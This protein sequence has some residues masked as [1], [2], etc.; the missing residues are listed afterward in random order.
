MID[1]T[2]NLYCVEPGI[3]RD[4]AHSEY[5]LH[6]GLLEIP[7]MDAEDA[8]PVVVRVHGRYTSRVSQFQYERES[9]PP[10]IPAPGDLMNYT[11]L[12]GEITIPAPAGQGAQG[13]LTFGARG[14]YRYVGVEDLRDY[15]HI[16]F[17]AHG[18][19]SRVDFLGVFD[20]NAPNAEESAG[21]NWNFPTFDLNILASNRILG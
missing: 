12:G 18:Y 13:N 2:R 16:R 14:E 1:T 7:V 5:R 15:G 4:I 19:I 9:M 3:R 8:T 6:E 21:F 20:M 17:D 11:Y 10:L